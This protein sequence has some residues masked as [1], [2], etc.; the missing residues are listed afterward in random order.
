MHAPWFV[1]RDLTKLP[2]MD[3]V[4]FDRAKVCHELAE[5]R[6]QMAVT[7]AVK[8]D[9]KRLADLVETDGT[10]AGEMC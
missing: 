2:H 5:M 1:A 6:R 9:V 10:Y 3:L 4:N 8:Q 7:E